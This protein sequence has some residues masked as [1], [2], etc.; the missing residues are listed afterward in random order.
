MA[1]FWLGHLI[2]TEQELCRDLPLDTEGRFLNASA[3]KIR[4]SRCRPDLS[5]KAWRK[6]MVEW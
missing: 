6:A 3:A 5:K 4:L 2:Y 1:A